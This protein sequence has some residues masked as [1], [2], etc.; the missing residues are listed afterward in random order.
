M[1]FEDLNLGLLQKCGAEF[2]GTMFLIIFCVGSANSTVLQS[3]GSSSPAYYLGI[4]VAFGLGNHKIEIEL[5][6]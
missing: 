5:K 3:L 4:S 1:G 6:D 2:F